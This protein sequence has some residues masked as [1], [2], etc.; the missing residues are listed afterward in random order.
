MNAV[1][2]KQFGGKLPKS[3]ADRAAAPAND[4]LRK[5]RPRWLLSRLRQSEIQSSE[6][7]PGAGFRKLG[8][9][10]TEGGPSVGNLAQEE[11]GHAAVEQHRHA[12]GL[13]FPLGQGLVRVAAVPGQGG[14]LVGPG[15]LPFRR[16][17]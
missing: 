4:R 16:N 10:F 15:S 17:G 7:M 8:D 5:F 11:S 12:R 1:T 9:G 2:T 14:M 13:R 6:M 3:L